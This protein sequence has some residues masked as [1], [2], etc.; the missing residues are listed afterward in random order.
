MHSHRAEF[1]ITKIV[2][3]KRQNMCKKG[4]FVA[5]LRVFD[6][7]AESFVTRSLEGLLVAESKNAICN[8]GMN[9]EK[10][11]A[12]KDRKQLKKSGVLSEH[13]AEK[14]EELRQLAQVIDL[15]EARTNLQPL[16]DLL[17]MAPTETARQRIESQISKLEVY[18][19]AAECPANDQAS[20]AWVQ[21][22]DSLLANTKSAGLATLHTRCFPLTP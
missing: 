9:K 6:C 4:N 15:T 12:F 7:V 1:Q 13:T 20:Q 14:T 16:K 22:Q 3:K 8:G 21:E 19:K 17:P 11:Q 5:P 18:I 2:N 10:R